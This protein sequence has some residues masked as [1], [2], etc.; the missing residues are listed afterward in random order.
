MI[1]ASWLK[2]RMVVVMSALAAACGAASA[3]EIYK[4]VDERGVT[5][6]S[7]IRPAGVK[8]ERM[9]QGTVS[10]IPGAPIAGQ[11][12]AAGRETADMEDAA[13]EALRARAAEQARIYEQRRQ[14]LMDACEANNGVDCAREADVE[15]RAQQIQERGNVIHSVPPSGPIPPTVILP[16]ATSTIPGNSLAR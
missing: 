10:I 14:L 16:P 4:W 9:P 1:P 15:L 12:G 8:W 6:Y 13:T 7:N 3:A 2:P 11:P 5:H